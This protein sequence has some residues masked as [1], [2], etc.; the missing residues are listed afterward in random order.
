MEESCSQGT[1]FVKIYDFGIDSMK[2]LISTVSL[3]M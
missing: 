3:Q 2:A 1:V